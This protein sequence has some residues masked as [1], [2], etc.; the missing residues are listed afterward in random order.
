M[1]K[2]LLDT[3]ILSDI[4][5][6][7]NPVV[8]ANAQTYRRSFGHYSFSTITVMEIVR[9]FQRAQS[10]QKLN[11]FI[12][13]LATEEVL[14]FDQAAAELAGRIVGDLERTG[15]PIGM[16]DPM[17]VSP[18]LKRGTTDPLSLRVMVHSLADRSDRSAGM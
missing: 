18:T 2:A 10:L 7:L 5:K 13:S 4:G 15:Q 16:A 11:A 12:A 6:G 8:N 3:D 9:G 1:N 14:S 17:I